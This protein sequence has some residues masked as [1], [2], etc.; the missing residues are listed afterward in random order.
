MVWVPLAVAAAGVVALAA[1][2]RAEPPALTSADGGA[3]NAAPAADAPNA[4][5]A[6]GVP[7]AAP[8]AGAPNT[9]A[10]A[11]SDRLSPERLLSGP[12][13]YETGRVGT[14]PQA[15]PKAIAPE[16]QFDL[17]REKA[18]DSATA[19]LPPAAPRAGVVDQAVLDQQIENRFAAL[20]NCRVDVARQK[21]VPPTEI[22][23][24][25]LTLR[26]TIRPNGVTAD[27]V[28]VA[29]SPVDIDVM[30]CVKTAMMRWKFM[31]P[32]GGP[33]RLERVFNF[34]ALQELEPPS[35]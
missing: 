18:V 28:V 3:P 21:R 32:R 19:S 17:G 35:H 23:A 4:A 13:L 6:A 27:T 9:A 26:W 14:A 31:A 24:T 29:S 2:A 22:L 10:P 7:N 25:T 16:E 5:P 15:T 20:E 1:A 34:R 8:S 30:S 11:D 12:S 33:V